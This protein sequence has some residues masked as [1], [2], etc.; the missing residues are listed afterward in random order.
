[1]TKALSSIFKKAEIKGP[2]HHTLYRKSAVSQCHARHKEISSNLADLMAHREGTAEK[3][4]RLFGKNKSS[5]KASKKL[6]GVMRNCEEN[7]KELRTRKAINKSSESELVTADSPGTERAPWKE[8]SLQALLNLFAEEISLQSVTM[9]LVREKIQSDPILCK[10]SPKRVY[11]R[12]RAEWRYK[13]QIHAIYF[14]RIK[15]ICFSYK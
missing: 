9:S 5:V 15:M 7:D 12:I 8:E 2:V 6:H 13:S 3:Y 14:L 1:M 4:Y 11:D 10:E